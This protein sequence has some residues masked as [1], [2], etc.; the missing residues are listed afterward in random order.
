M[1][2]LQLVS[3]LLFVFAVAA[4]S[5]VITGRV[6]R[7]RFT[8]LLFAD[9]EKARLVDIEDAILALQH[10][11][12]SLGVS[13][14]QSPT[15][16]TLPA[17][18]D[19]FTSSLRARG[20][21]LSITAP[22]LSMQ[23]PA[24]CNDPMLNIY[25]EGQSLD[26]ICRASSPAWLSRFGIVSVSSTT[27]QHGAI[28]VTI[29]L[30]LASIRQIDAA[31]MQEFVTSVVRF[32]E[33]N[34][35]KQ[36]S[37]TPT[38]KHLQ[39]ITHDIRSPLHN[40]RHALEL[41][42]LEVDNPSVQSYLSVALQNIASVA[43]LTESILDFSSRTAGVVSTQ[44]STIPLFDVVS[45]VIHRFS[46]TMALKNITPHVLVDRT[47]SIVFDREQFVRVL[48]N[49][50][51][52]AIKYSQSGTITIRARTE[53]NY[54]MLSVTDQGIGMTP[55]QVQQLFQ[56][57]TRFQ[58]QLAEGAGIGLVITKQILEA[59]QASIK[60]ESDYGIGTTF[61]LK[62]LGT[63]EIASPFMECHHEPLALKLLHIEDN[64]DMQQSLM[65][66]LEGRGVTIYCA[67][68]FIEAESIVRF[69]SFDGIISDLETGQ[70]SIETFLEQLA[71]RSESSPVLVVSGRPLPA[72]LR[73]RVEYLKKPCNLEDIQ[74]WLEKL[75][76]SRA[77]A[78]QA[79]R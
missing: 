54:V 62:L 45:E 71:R 32:V 65:R 11:K 52:N 6:I 8:R 44:Q 2:A 7:Q 3:T 59:N 47:V 23:L 35:L 53:K 37:A 72:S 56:P 34:L 15:P 66:S 41:A 39:E 77:L 70:G 69:Q 16:E 48:S 31:S 36:P 38:T 13:A 25:V 42:K 26:A 18:F 20:G 78:Q 19:G 30:G 9:N 75:S 22:G 4:V 67:H 29:W 64:R 76:A 60:V 17:L 10:K 50:I 46:V 33:H 43:D 28:T 68:N 63:A 14:K 21:F 74:T 79:L 24:L 40:V 73:T 27:E 1:T 49:L 57:F 51:S 58:R 55:D 12:L 5:A 61:T